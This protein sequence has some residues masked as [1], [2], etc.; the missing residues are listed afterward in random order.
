MGEFAAYARYYDLLYRDKDYEAEAAFVLDAFDRT[1]CRPRSLLELGCGSGR[2]ACAMAAR[3]VEVWATDRSESMLAL[4]R[5]GASSLPADCPRPRFLPADAR[6]LR[7]DRSF[8]AAMA[9]FHVMSYQTSEDDAMAVFSGVKRHLE[10]GGTFFFDFW[11]GPGVVRDPPGERCKTV[12]DDSVRIERLARPTHRT[13]DNLVEVRYSLRVHNKV[14]GG[15]ED[16]EETHILRYWFLPELRRLAKCAGLAVA[17]CGA[18]M[19]NELPGP[20]S[21]YAWMGLRA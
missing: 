17:G 21:W 11:H 8:A 20:D 6:E 4:A 13:G 3:G 19:T 2:H 14:E 5:R 9:L 1:G 12:E 18:W 16:V 10:P 7:L 15:D